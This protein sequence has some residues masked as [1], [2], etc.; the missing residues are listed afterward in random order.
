M[1]VLV[2]G[3]T[4]FIGSRL[5]LECQERGDAVRVLGLENTPLEAENRQRLE[6]SGAE[7]IV[8]SV[9]DRETVDEGLKGIDTVFHLAAAQHEMNVPDEHF[10]DINVGGTE[11]LLRASMRH[12][13]RRFIHGSTIG[14]YGSLEGTIS[15]ESPCKPDNIYGRT[16]LE[17]E[18]VV[19]AAS[20]EFP[21]VVIRIPEVYG[22]GDRRLLKLF[23]AI[24]RG[25]FLHIGSGQK[26]RITLSTSAIS[27]PDF[28]RQPL[29]RLRWARSCCFRVET[30]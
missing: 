28:W 16:K 20:N 8:G 15:E 4:G 7:V 6:E 17:G 14:V 3:G 2:T 18:S 25:L 5:A 21:V 24:D 13:V 19:L 30:W 27:F 23:R 9:T 12:G 22:P 11:N 26:T 10:R 1:R 29:R